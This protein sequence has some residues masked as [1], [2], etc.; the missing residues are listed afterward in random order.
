[1]DKGNMTWDKEEFFEKFHLFLDNIIRYFP[2]FWNYSLFVVDKEAVTVGNVV[3]GIVWLACIYLGVRFVAS[4]ID[5]RLISRLDIDTTHRYTIKVLLSYISFFIFLLVAFYFI[6][7]PLGVVAVIGTA[8]GAGIGLGGQNIM[9]SLLSGIVIVTEHPIREGDIIEIYDPG[10]KENLLG[11]VENIGFRATTIRSY[12]N[13][14]ILVPNNV[15]L[16]KN[17]LNWTLSDKVIRS[18]VNVA[19]RYGSPI[20]KVRDILLKVA[21]EHEKV[22]TYDKTQLPLV[23]FQNFGDNGLLFELHFWIVMDYPFAR[24]KVASEIRFKINEMFKEEGIVVPFPQRD[25]HFRNP[26]EISRKDP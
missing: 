4:Q 6:K 12:D 18:R 2:D 1:M 15:I 20:E 21:Y 19:V 16:E 13:T 24:L 23:L 14:N 17:V 9:N 3:T 11:Q 26:I 22:L 25:L 5:K 7:V 10:G 8:I